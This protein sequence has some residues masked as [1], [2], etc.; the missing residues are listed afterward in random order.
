M[1]TACFIGNSHVG[2]LRRALPL[3]EGGPRQAAFAFAP[4]LQ[5]ADAAIVDG[6]LEG[7]GLRTAFWPAR[8]DAV[9]RVRLDDYD[10]HVMVGLGLAPYDVAR[11]YE[12]HRLLRHATKDLAV[13]SP[14]C[15]RSAARCIVEATLAVRM[16]RAVK[17]QTAGPV[18]IMAQPAL[19]ERVLTASS[20]PELKRRPD[21]GLILGDAE[22]GTF[23]HGVFVEAVEAAL[24]GTGVRF[25][26]QPEETRRHG[27]TRSEYGHD[28]IPDDVQHGGARYGAVMLRQLDRAWQRP[29][30][31][32]AS[33]QPELSDA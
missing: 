5:L 33:L 21:L 17:A 32:P 13:L 18:F 28:G 8:R 2:C 1:V 24:E 3:P 11:I 6:S 22:L 29:G 14:D 31:A 30:D 25:I 23:L 20:T 27:L 15:L 9:Q 16:A 12:R 26:D 7:T 4:R 19:S 10:V